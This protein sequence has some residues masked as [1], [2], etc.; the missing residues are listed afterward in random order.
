M[1]IAKKMINENPDLKKWF[2]K[3]IRKTGIAVLTSF[4]RTARHFKKPLF[5][6]AMIITFEFVLPWLFEAKNVS[7]NFII[8][9]LVWAMIITLQFVLPWLFLKQNM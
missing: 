5:G 4:V 1:R 8:N 9:T 3:V 7:P 6:R 2:L